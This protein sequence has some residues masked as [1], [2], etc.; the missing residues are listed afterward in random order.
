MDYTLIIFAASV[1]FVSLDAFKNNKIVK[2]TEEKFT[3]Y[4]QETKSCKSLL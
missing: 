1:L 2:D 3:I 4:K